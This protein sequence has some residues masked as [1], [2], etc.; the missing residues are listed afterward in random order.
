MA[1]G[2]DLELVRKKHKER[3]PE[4]GIT[5]GYAGESR[6]IIT[7]SSI[8]ASGLQIS[9]CIRTT[10]KLQLHKDFLRQRFREKSSYAESVAD[11]LVVRV[12]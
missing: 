3:C 5:E 2:F 10:G 8:T 7:W 11:I 9:G 6:W 12:F 4:D 1:N